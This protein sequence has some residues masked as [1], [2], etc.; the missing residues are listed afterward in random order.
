V[1]GGGDLSVH[2]QARIPGEVYDRQRI[3]SEVKTRAS[4][5]SDDPV[6]DE[7]GI[8]RPGGL[9]RI[10]ETDEPKERGVR[11]QLV[12]NGVGILA[13]EVCGTDARTIAR[14]AV[15]SDGGSLPALWGRTEGNPVRQHENGGGSITNGVRTSGDQPN[16]LRVQQ[17]LR[18]R[19]DPVPGIPPGNERESRESGEVDG[20]AAR[21]RRRIRDLGGFGRDR[22]G[23][24]PGMEPRAF[25]S[26]AGAPDRPFSKRKGI[27][28]S[29]TASRHPGELP[30]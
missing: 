12:S 26:D 15:S 17:R 18:I 4:Q 1:Y 27:F 11:V 24:E 29:V 23:T 20:A 10:D 14:N 16:V 28:E 19:S 22:P 7:S 13:T 2:R 25:A 6:R 30:Y 5:E 21:L 8:A 9:E 3:L